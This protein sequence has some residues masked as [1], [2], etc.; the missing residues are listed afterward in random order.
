M[1]SIIILSFMVIFCQ[2]LNIWSESHWI[3]RMY[4]LFIEDV[5]GTTFHANFF[6][7]HTKFMVISSIFFFLTLF[8][9]ALLQ[10]LLLYL[11]KLLITVIILLFNK[12]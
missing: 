2:F 12:F 11:L 6:C 7:F 9:L 1:N 8:E 4:V 10:N 5:F 3:F